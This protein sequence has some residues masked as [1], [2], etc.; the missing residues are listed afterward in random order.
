MHEQIV[1][2]N[3]GS[4]IGFIHA[5]LKGLRSSFIDV[6]EKNI[7]L[8]TENLKVQDDRMLIRQCRCVDPTRE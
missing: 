2:L 1:A 3:N 6:M 7:T 5:D 8:I 4:R